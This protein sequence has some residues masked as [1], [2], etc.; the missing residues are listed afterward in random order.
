[1]S[2]IKYC[3]RGEKKLWEH[4]PEPTPPSL[5]ASDLTKPAVD[6]PAS[7]CS[8]AT[9]KPPNSALLQPSTFTQEPLKL[10]LFSMGEPNRVIF[11][12]L[13]AQGVMCRSPAA[14]SPV[15]LLDVHNGMPIFAEPQV[16]CVCVEVHD[17]PSKNTSPKCGFPV[18]ILL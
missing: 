15:G 2:F 7:V 9:I 4:P 18:N 8:W 6:R 13:A 1:M 3:H 5:P 11:D 12:N 17:I 14:V 10:R 16:I